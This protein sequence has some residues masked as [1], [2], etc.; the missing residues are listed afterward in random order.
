[1]QAHNYQISSLLTLAL[2]LTFPRATYAQNDWLQGWREATVSIGKI[3]SV[4]VL[5][6]ATGKPTVKPGGDTLRVQYFRVL[7]TG[8][9][10]SAP[11][12]TIRAPFLV[13]AKHVFHNPKENW[14]PDSLRLRFTW[15]ADKSVTDY[16]GIN[17]H[18]KDVN[19]KR[20]WVAHPDPSVD[21]AILQI[22]ISRQEAGRLTVNPVGLDNLALLDEVFEGANVLLFGYPGSVGSRYWT[23]PIIRHGV[24]AYVDPYRFGKV[25]ILVDAMVF[26]GN[27]GGPVFTVPTGMNKNGSFAVGRRSAFLGIVSSTFRESIEVEKAAAHLLDTSSDTSKTHYKSFNFMGLAVVEPAERV[28]ELLN[29]IRK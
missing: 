12:T 5:N 23:K 6:Q 14:D 26:P 21:L 4:I 25:P 2:L 22:V 8:V 18:L 7:G 20:L 13:T 10:F 1:M 15:F 11:D 17:F 9:I 28:R 3:D 27:S 24:I 19:R 29:L 16:L